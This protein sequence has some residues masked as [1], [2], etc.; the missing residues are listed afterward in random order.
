MEESLM[1]KRG[2][3]FRGGAVA[4]GVVLSEVGQARHLQ[5]HCVTPGSAGKGPLDWLA[6]MARV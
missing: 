2:Q 3:M 4:G 5:G 1:Q 6:C